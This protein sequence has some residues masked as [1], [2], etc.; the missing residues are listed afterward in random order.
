MLI[1][2]LWKHQIKQ[3]LVWKWDSYFN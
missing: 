1:V 3:K 2:L